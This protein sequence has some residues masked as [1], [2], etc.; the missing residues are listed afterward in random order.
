[1]DIHLKLQA[2]TRLPR[3]VM[4]LADGLLH[5]QENR[6]Y[7]YKG[8]SLFEKALTFPFDISIYIFSVVYLFLLTQYVM[9]CIKVLHLPDEK[10][11]PPYKGGKP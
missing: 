1:V 2:N 7:L 10:I 8:K 3:R 6:K 4:V 9:F 11:Y 5:F